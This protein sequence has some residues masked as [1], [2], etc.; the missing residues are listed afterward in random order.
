M[1]GG[2]LETTHTR[3]L[4]TTLSI[5]KYVNMRD[6]VLESGLGQENNI[7]RDKM[8]QEVLTLIKTTLLLTRYESDGKI[9]VVRN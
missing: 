9:D 7:P 5:Y 8:L 3:F 4:I 2:I 1:S 6:L